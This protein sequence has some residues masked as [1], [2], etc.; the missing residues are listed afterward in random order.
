MMTT[1]W[2]HGTRSIQ[3]ADP[4]IQGATSA[5]DAADLVTAEQISLTDISRVAAATGIARRMLMRNPVTSLR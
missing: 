5:L 1:S 3:P 2:I 4:Q